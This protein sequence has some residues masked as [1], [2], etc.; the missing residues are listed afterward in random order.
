MSQS[1]NLTGQFTVNNGSLRNLINL[2]TNT[3]TTGS[4]SICNNA[5]VPSGSWSLIDQGSNADFRI[6]IFKNVDLTSSIKVA[7][8]SSATS[9][10]SSYLYPGDTAILYGSGSTSIYAF[11]TGTNT[12]GSLQYILSER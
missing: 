8:G 3:T 12:T 2:A 4:N 10:F 7:L 5:N 6:G 9:S 1:I 11:A